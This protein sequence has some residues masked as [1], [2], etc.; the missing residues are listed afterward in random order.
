MSPRTDPRIRLSDP[1]LTPFG[2]WLPANRSFYDC[3]RRWLKDGG[4]G[5]AA[6]RI[7]GAAA[8]LAL[9][10][11]AKPYWQLVL[12]DDLDTVRRHLVEHY[13]PSTQADYAKGLRKLE[14]YLRL[15]CRRSARPDEPNWPY[16]VG[17]LPAWLAD[18]VR[19]FVAHRRRAWVHEQRLK[20]THSLLSHLTLFLRWAAQTTP[21]TTVE[22]LTPALWFDYVDAR[23]AAA[24]SPAT[25]NGQLA[26]LHHFLQFL[27]EQ[28]HP[29]CKRLL[30]VE[31]LPQPA[32]L[33]R[34]VPL[35]HVRRL[36]AAVE[37]AAATSHAGIERCG[38]MD[39]AW[40]CLMLYSGLRTGEVRRLQCVDLDFD[41]L[42]L[43]IEQSKGLQDR[44]VPL[45]QATAEAL[46]TYLPLRGPADGDHVFL[47]RHQPL[48]VSYCYERLRTYGE[49]CGVTITPH[50]LRHTCATL[51]LNAGAPILTVQTILGHRHIDTTLGYAR[52][53]DGTL[54]HD[55]YAAM[56]TVEQNVEGESSEEPAAPPVI[57]ALIAMV[58]DLQDGTLS[59]T[60]R[61][62]VCEL[63]AALLSL[64]G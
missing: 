28:D 4:Y 40:V 38:T 20:A 24:V 23:L 54:A 26:E 3:F 25:L 7:Y 47:Y 44:T 21:L 17:S 53:Y 36:L 51:L 43:R 62:T 18:D 46:R 37:A 35:T 11:L 16:F 42:R 22:A 41:A 45:S 29:V 59:D 9:G 19:A 57:D 15:R 32:R 10:L 5:S 14:A 6:L 49:Q 33:P 13:A 8:R 31:G 52:L 58:D 63:R 27:A 61:E 48:S 34:D 56:Q 1:A 55:Y 30:R 39:R 60:Q 50:Q 12:P 2:A 64:S